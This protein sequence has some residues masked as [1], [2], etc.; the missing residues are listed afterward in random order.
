MTDKP[1]R[2]CPHCGDL[3]SADLCCGFRA[4]GTAAIPA[5]VMAL[6][7]AMTGTGTDWEAVVDGEAAADGAEWDNRRPEP[8]D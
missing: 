3:T 5:D 7:R 1:K 2:R 4:D 6:V 8:Q